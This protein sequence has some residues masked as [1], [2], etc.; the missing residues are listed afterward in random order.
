MKTPLWYEEKTDL[1]EKYGI[2]TVDAPSLSEAERDRRWLA[3]RRK[4]FLRKLDCLV[5][6]GNDLF[7]GM[8]MANV[9]YMTQLNSS[10]TTVCVFPL[11]GDPIAFNGPPHMNLPSHQGRARGAWVDDVRPNT[12]IRAV[13]DAIR[14]LGFAGGSIGVVGFGTHH[15]GNNLPWYWM[16]A[17]IES[18]PDGKVNDET[19]LLNEARM[20]KSE[21]EITL[22]RR[23]GEV[24]LRRV[25]RMIAE[26]RPGISERELWAAMEHEQL[27]AGGE[28][29]TFNLLSSGAI[30]DPVESGL[31]HLLHGIESPASPTGSV[32]DVGHLVV[33]EF[34]TQVEG[35]LAATEFSLFLGDPPSE[36]ERIHQ[37]AVACHQAALDN[38]AP[39]AVLRDT[40]RAIR[41]P[42]EAEGMD[43]VELG[44]HGHGL[45]SPE[46]PSG[47][48][49]REEDQHVFGTHT[50]GAHTF[51]VGMVLGLNVDVH[52]PSWR[53]DVGVM[54]G[55]MVVVTED[56]CEPL[57]GIPTDV[58]GLSVA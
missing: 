47:I 15:S 17:L 26:A 32:L 38:I 35:Y 56:G 28:P 7:Y 29:Q 41:A 1:V 36:L 6:F 8:G 40:W 52:D 27:L 57:V 5:L 33:C 31:Q 24:A 55:D 16:N 10:M 12:G 22:L 9:R 3:V 20:I 14:D 21:E 54:L 11:V 42:M 39:G 50:I 13:V 58:F 49:Y 23:A 2:A 18:L 25:Q 45:A 30:T 34:H 53:K 51:E 37:T 48:V 43:F 4:M 44:F 46:Y 19:A